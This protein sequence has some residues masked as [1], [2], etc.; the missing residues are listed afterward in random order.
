MDG[1]QKILD[2]K[3]R[4]YQRRASDIWQCATYLEGKNHRASTREASITR[5]KEFAERWYLDLK[6]R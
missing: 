3:V 1:V 2:G 4:R 6:H 5:A